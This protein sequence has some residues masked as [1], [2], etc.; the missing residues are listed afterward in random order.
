MA[1]V[2]ICSTDAVYTGI[3][4][5]ISVRT[6]E[7][8]LQLNLYYHWYSTNYWENW[9]CV[10]K[11]RGGEYFLC[12]KG[13]GW[14][15][16]DWLLT[17]ACYP[18]R[19]MKFGRRWHCYGRDSCTCSWGKAGWNKKIILFISSSILSIKI[20]SPGFQDSRVIAETHNI[21]FFFGGGG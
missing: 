20:T 1:K 15:I 6:R 8:R 12:M 11:G 18:P 14:D 13:S 16:R 3:I 9:P 7:W 17:V 2:G 10:G 19:L 5:A 4:D 21:Q